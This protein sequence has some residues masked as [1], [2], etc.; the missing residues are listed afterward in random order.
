MT[1]KDDKSFTNLELGAGCGNFGT[2]FHP[3]C[4]LTDGCDN[5]LQDRCKNNSIHWFC[6]ANELPWGSDRF[7]SVIICNPYLYGFKDYDHSVPLFTEILRVLKK[8]GT[9]IIIGTKNNK[10]CPET[11]IVKTANKALETLN[12][13]TYEFASEEFVAGTEYAGYE[14]KTIGNAIISPPPSK[15]YI[16]KINKIQTESAT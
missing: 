7:N 5:K 8:Q 14:F 6:K 1:L 11:R 16:I 12:S 10:F 13:F 4:Y 3:K 15:R 9:I 2:Q